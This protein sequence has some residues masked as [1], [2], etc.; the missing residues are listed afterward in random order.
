MFA[1]DAGDW[2]MKYEITFDPATWRLTYDDLNK[3]LEFVKSPKDCTLILNPSIQAEFHEGELPQT[4]WIDEK[5]NFENWIS[6]DG[7]VLPECI[8]AIKNLQKTAKKLNPR[9]F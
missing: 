6:V 1:L 4:M 7:K 2:Q 8:E 5:G 3:L 9:Q